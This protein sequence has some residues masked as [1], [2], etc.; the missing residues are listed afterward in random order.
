MS[1]VKYDFV[2]DIG[3]KVKVKDL[4]IKGKVAGIFISKSGIEYSVRYFYENS[5]K[6]CYFNSDELELMTDEEIALGFNN[7]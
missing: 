3:A 6:L 7:K 4:A 2:F 1:K 5:Q